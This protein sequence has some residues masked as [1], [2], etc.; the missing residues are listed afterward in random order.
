MMTKQCRFQRIAAAVLTAAF[1]VIVPHSV[2]SQTD[3]GLVVG[4]VFNDTDLS[5]TPTGPVVLDVVVDRHF[6]GRLDPG[7]SMDIALAPRP[8]PYDVRAY[9]F[10]YD[11][12]S[13]FTAVDLPLTYTVVVPISHRDKLSSFWIAFEGI[14]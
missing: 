7:T 5:P 13:F 2:I 6:M 12:S 1:L 3:E 11:G 10:N 8:D 14:H 9:V 4:T